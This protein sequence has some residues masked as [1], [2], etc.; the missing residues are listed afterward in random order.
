MEKPR[1]EAVSEGV[2][3]LEQLLRDFSAGKV[4][5]VVLTYQTEDGGNKHQLVGEFADDLMAAI[6]Q[7]RRLDVALNRHFLRPES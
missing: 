7:V 1:S 4:S 2:S 6:D 5:G 3:V